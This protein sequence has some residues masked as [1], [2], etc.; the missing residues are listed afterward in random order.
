V[1]IIVN[2]RNFDWQVDFGG[3]FVGIIE[4]DQSKKIFKLS[5]SSEDFEKNLKRVN[6]DQF[7]YTNNGLNISL[8]IQNEVNGRTKMVT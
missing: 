8:L 3:I 2:K 4:K 6:N 5:L 1:G 7:V